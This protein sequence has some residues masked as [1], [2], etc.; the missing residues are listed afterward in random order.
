M[1]SPQSLVWSILQWVFV[2]GKS[3]CILG[4][5]NQTWLQLWQ[6]TFLHELQ[7]TWVHSSVNII[8]PMCFSWKAYQEKFY[9]KILSFYLGIITSKQMMPVDLVFSSLLK[10]QNKSPFVCN[11]YNFVFNAQ[12][13]FAFLCYSWNRVCRVPWFRCVKHPFYLLK[14]LIIC[15]ILWGLTVMSQGILKIRFS[16]FF[17]F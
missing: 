6:S 14:L 17:R 7:L 9:K 11:V 16:L 1:K 4:G 10:I 8:S 15:D 12:Q 2:A 3:L 5:V 13:C